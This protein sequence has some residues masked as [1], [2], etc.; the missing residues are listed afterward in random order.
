MKVRDTHNRLW[1]IADQQGGFFTARQAISVGFSDNTHPYHVRVGNWVRECRGVYRLVR[2][3]L[4]EN[5]QLIRWAFWS[6]DRKEQIQGIYSYLTALCI[7]DLSDAMPVQLDMT[8]PPNFR[9]NSPIPPVLKLHRSKLPNCDIMH[10]SGYAVTTPIRSILDVIG[11]DIVPRNIVCQ[12]LREARKRGL[13]TL[14]EFKQSVEN[15][16]LPS[17]AIEQVVMENK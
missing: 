12:A 17:W 13:V 6:R 16:E 11:S 4:N 14:S 2:Y 3:P 1:D 9:R 7:H 5:A 8:V 15:D 10:R